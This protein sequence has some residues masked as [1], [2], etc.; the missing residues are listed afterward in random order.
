M[1]KIIRKRKRAY[2]IALHLPKNILVEVDSG[3]SNPCSSRPIVHKTGKT[4]WY[5]I[6]TTHTC[7]CKYV[8]RYTY[9]PKW[10]QPMGQNFYLKSPKEQMALLECQEESGIENSLCSQRAILL[11]ANT[12]KMGKKKHLLHPFKKS[13]LSDYKSKYT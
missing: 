1:K 4:A 6:H 5:V 10:L 7:G 13:Y 3:S 11:D 8:N 2:N 12:W 9:Y